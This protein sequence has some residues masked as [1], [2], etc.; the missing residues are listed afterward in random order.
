MRRR[1]AGLQGLCPKP[2]GL[3]KASSDQLKHRKLLR[4]MVIRIGPSREYFIRHELFCTDLGLGP[5]YGLMCR[6]SELKAQKRRAENSRTLVHG[7][8][9]LPADPSGKSAFMPIC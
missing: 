2:Y 5:T 6:P 9:C 1:C 8:A 3:P 4:S 7:S